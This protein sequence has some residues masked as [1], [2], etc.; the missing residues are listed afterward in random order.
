M[1]QIIQIC[2]LKHFVYLLS[3]LLVLASCTKT[4]D[5]T[6][7]LE[8]MS[9]EWERGI[10]ENPLY[11]SSMGKLEKND[12]WPVYSLEQIRL[13]HSH[14]KNILL[15]LN[16]LDT[17]NFSSDNLLNIK[18]FKERY[19]KSLELYEFKSFLVPFSHRGGIQLQHESAETLP[20][21]TVAHFQDWI[22]RLSTIDKY[23]NGH[24]Q[25]AKEG[26]KNDIV[27]PR[28]L[29]E[30]V[31]DQIEKQAFVTS[32]ESPFYKAFTEMPS[33]IPEDIQI[34][35]QN[36][37][38]NVIEEIVIPSYLNFYNFFKNEYLPQC[39]KTIGINQI[40]NGDEYYEALARQFTTTNL[41][42]NQIH[43]I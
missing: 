4:S 23:I 25:V 39:R 42:P 15:T 43:E 16:N 17:Q 7:F 5:E 9:S 6:I 22:A 36:K 32:K 18:L 8:L 33:S 1:V 30:R 34:E 35:L 19:E 37:A 26:I 40:P 11:A 41:N 29:M 10:D 24:I 13:N 3:S 38:L 20:L 28:I 21:R 2:K 27:P 12:Q 14:E 31:L